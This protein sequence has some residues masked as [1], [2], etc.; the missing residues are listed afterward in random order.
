MLRFIFTAAIFV[1]V[2]F[3]AVSFM[4]AEDVSPFKITEDTGCLELVHK[5]LIRHVAFSPDGK[6]LVAASDDGV[7][8][9]WDTAT[10]KKL[11]TI[12]QKVHFLRFSPDSKKVVAACDDKKEAVIWDVATGQKEQTFENKSNIYYA[13]FSPNGKLLLT[14]DSD[15]SWKIWSVEKG[16]EL[17]N[18]DSFAPTA[19]F[20]SDGK[21][22]LVRGV[23]GNGIIDIMTGKEVYEDE[24][25]IC[26][27]PDGTK[28]YKWEEI[29]AGIFDIQTEKMLEEQLKKVSEGGENALLLTL[30]YRTR[31]DM[32]ANV[33]RSQGYGT[34]IISA[35]RKR[36]LLADSIIKVIS[37]SEIDSGNLLSYS[38]PYIKKQIVNVA[39]DILDKEG[40]KQLPKPYIDGYKFFHFTT[41]G[42]L[43]T[44]RCETVDED[45]KE[46]TTVGVTVIG[47]DNFI[48]LKDYGIYDQDEELQISPD[49]NY[50]ARL[51]RKGDS[52]QIYDLK[53]GNNICKIPGN[54]DRDFGVIIS[55]DNKKFMVQVGDRL[56]LWDIKSAEK[57]HKQIIERQQKKQ[58]DEDADTL[59]QDALQQKKQQDADT[60]L[61]DALQ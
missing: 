4:K 20:S 11:Q 34:A 9:I 7:I 21:K 32:H 25:C 43:M 18:I 39:N 49:G 46:N 17:K 2:T 59:L 36:V 48:P 22:I 57:I 3:A 35:D 6:L 23:S 13:E 30:G 8:I 10:G 58:Q 16:I 47:K 19:T 24:G 51:N 53:T 28:V 5:G 31:G 55:P 42:E 37:C 44:I 26:F 41:D 54:Y 27:S 29:D 15:S 1:G 56:Q 38:T 52:F 14:K 12:Q 33:F 40:K 60:L 50:L 45:K 61:Q